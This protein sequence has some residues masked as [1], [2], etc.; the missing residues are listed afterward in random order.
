M[1]KLVNYVVA[2]A[3]VTVT[4]LGAVS[5]KKRFCSSRQGFYCGID[6]A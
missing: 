5:Q 4:I 6:S 3:M 1:R 2:I